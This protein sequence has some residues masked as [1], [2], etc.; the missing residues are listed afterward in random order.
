MWNKGR[1]Y[2]Q[3]CQGRWNGTT[4]S[5]M[6]DTHSSEL[7][8]RQRPFPH[9]KHALDYFSC[10]NGS[11]KGRGSL[12]PLLLYVDPRYLADGGDLRRHRTTLSVAN[13]GRSALLLLVTT[14]PWHDWEDLLAQRRMRVLLSSSVFYS[15]VRWVTRYWR[16]QRRSMLADV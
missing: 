6:R 9:S 14:T 3:K 2:T 7:K 4:G 8:I 15:V 10:H 11:D 13:N 1:R 16:S 5:S 12:T